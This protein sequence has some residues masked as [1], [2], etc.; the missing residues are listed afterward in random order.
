MCNRLLIV[1]DS[2]T[3]RAI[4]KRTIQMAGVSV[5]MFSEAAN[6]KEALNLLADKPFDLVL[7]D[8]NMP[9]MGG[10]ELTQRMQA[11]PSTASIPVVVISA[12]PNAASLVQ[13]HQDGIRGYLRKPFTPER[14]RDLI[15]PLLGVA[16]A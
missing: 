1:D 7:V 2:A 4:I 11:N 9:E 12:E 16:H 14:I 15:S 6:G 8:L 5:D 3:T 10:L 13:V